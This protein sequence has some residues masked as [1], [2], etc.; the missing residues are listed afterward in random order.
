MLVPPVWATSAAA[1]TVLGDVG[2]V[3]AGSSL[4]NARRVAVAAVTQDPCR[5]ALGNVGDVAVAVLDDRRGLHVVELE[6]LGTVEIA[7]LIDARRA[8]DVEGARVLLD[9]GDVAVAALQDGRHVVRRGRTRCR[10]RRPA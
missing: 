8:A 6:D 10:R 4:V 3:A 7:R 1:E 2:D 9:V 5:V